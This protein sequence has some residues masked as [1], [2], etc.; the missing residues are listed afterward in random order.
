LATIGEKNPV[1]GKGS[2]RGAGVGRVVQ[3]IRGSEKGAALPLRLK[4][5]GDQNNSGRFKKK[6]FL[7]KAG[8]VGVTKE[9]GFTIVKKKGGTD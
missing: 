2:D 3:K 9:G 7:P 5:G 6:D 4:G 8:P 1:Q